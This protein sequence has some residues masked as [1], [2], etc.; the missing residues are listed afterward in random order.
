MKNYFLLLLLITGSVFSQNVNT[1]KKTALRDAKA[2]SKASVDRNLSQMLKYTHPNIFKAFGEEQLME[3]MNDNFRTMDAQN[4]KVKKSKIDE[5]AELKKEGKEYRC[6]IKNTVEMDFSGRSVVIKGSLF[7]F[8]DSKK[9][10]WYF[11]ES[12][13]LIDDPDTQ[14]LFPN[15]KT[16]IDIPL[17]E[18]IAEN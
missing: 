3:T 17:D 14:K 7:G 9:S 2:T 6:L 18:H 10:Q 13:K 16:D 5:I 1:L 15:F 8:Y 4:I 11:V 12:N